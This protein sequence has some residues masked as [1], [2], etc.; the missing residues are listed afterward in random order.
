M[1][2]PMNSYVSVPFVKN[3]QIVY[4]RL[5]IPK[6]TLELEKIMKNIDMDILMNQLDNISIDAK[7]IK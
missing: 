3:E 7:N 6:N 5:P 4:K 1:P 2:S